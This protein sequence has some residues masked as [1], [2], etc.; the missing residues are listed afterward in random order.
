M[1]QLT[2]GLKGQL[3]KLV[4]TADLASAYGNPGVDVLSSMTLMTLLEGSCL[5]AIEGGLEPGQMTVG[6]RMEMDHLAPTPASFT[7]TAT[8]E[9]LEVKGPKL[10][11]A[12][13]AHDG[14]EQVARGRHVRFVVEH[15]RFFQGVTQ[16]AAKR[17]EV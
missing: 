16:K 15:E 17:S 4:E 11:F 6:A 8:A 12:V 1:S 5:R 10:V 2:P 3:G 7:V 14:V 13:S 9:L